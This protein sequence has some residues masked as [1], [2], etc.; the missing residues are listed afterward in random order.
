MTS[1]IE[2]STKFNIEEKPIDPELIRKKEIIA[3]RN[4]MDNFMST[5]SAMGYQ[6]KEEINHLETKINKLE[7]I[8]CGEMYRL[9]KRISLLEEMV[10]TK[11]LYIEETEG[12]E[13][14]FGE[15]SQCKGVELV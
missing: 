4:R 15:W 11:A 5:Q 7:E 3:I 8:L 6:R 1:Q 2:N 14:K 9:N 12:I 13:E 10:Y